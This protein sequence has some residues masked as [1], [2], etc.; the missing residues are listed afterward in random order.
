MAVRAMATPAFMS[1]VPGPQRRPS[2]D[3]ARHGLE[4]AEGPDGVEMA[5]EKDAVF[6]VGRFG[7]EAGFEDIAK[8]ALPVKL[9]AAA[10]GAC[11][12]ATRATQASTADLSS[13]GD[14]AATSCG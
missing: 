7:S 9:D 1:S 10:Q 3:P 2:I 13:V 8:V 6:G 12:E 11:A 14:S 5:E 4:S